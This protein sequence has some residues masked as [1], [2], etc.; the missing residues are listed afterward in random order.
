MEKKFITKEQKEKV[1]NRLIL[2]FAILLSGALLLLYVF[3]FNMGY[4]TQVKS[5]LGVLG[6][7]FAVVGIAMLVFGFVKKNTKLKRYSSIFFGAFIPCALVSYV[8]KLPL[9]ANSNYTTK[10]AVGISLILM[11]VYFVVL[12]IYT[13]VYLHTHPVLIE[14]KKI[15]HKK[16]KK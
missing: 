2:N 13:A 16:K 10:T 3:N 4:P 14:K 9:V 1:G 8:S 6:I 7:V 12:A 15:H 11:V 5:V